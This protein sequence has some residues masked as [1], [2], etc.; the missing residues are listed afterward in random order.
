MAW[1]ALAGEVIFVG[2]DIPVR[3]HPIQTRGPARADA[4]ERL[5]FPGRQLLYC[6]WIREHERPVHLK[7]ISPDTLERGNCNVSATV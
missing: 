1:P 6:L 7:H 4:S 2:A 5:R 3:E